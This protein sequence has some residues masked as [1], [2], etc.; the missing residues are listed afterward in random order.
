MKRA[1]RD[2]AARATVVKKLLASNDCLGPALGSSA[3]AGAKP[4]PPKK[5]QVRCRRRGLAGAVDC[6][7]KR[8]EGQ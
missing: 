1:G 2:R 7:G 6:V 8:I 5:H 3:L 4:P